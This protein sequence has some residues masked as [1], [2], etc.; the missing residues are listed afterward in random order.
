MSKKFYI[1]AVVILVFIIGTIVFITPGD[2]EDSF[3]GTVWTLKTDLP[4]ATQ[5]EMARLLDISVGLRTASESAWLTARADYLYNEVILE[6]P[7]GDIVMALG[8]EVPTGITRFAKGATFYFEDKAAG[9]RG[10][11]EN[12]GTNTDAVWE[13]TGLQQSEITLSSA[14]FGTIS[15]T[16]VTLVPDPGDGYVV[17]L[18]TVMGR[19]VFSSEA[20]SGVD[21]GFEIKQENSTG[22]NVIASFS[23]GFSNGGVLS[24]AASPSFETMIPVGLVA[25]PS[26]PLILTAS[27]SHT[28]DGDTYFKFKAFYYIWEY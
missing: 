20:W 12:I 3:G 18:V 4:I 1:V 17:Q 23:K 15:T 5:L 14:S 8:R 2:R 9:L 19:R 7:D 16:P 26:E 6:N 25:S 21:E 22:L 13:A 10:Q 11:Y 24:S 28:I 27:S